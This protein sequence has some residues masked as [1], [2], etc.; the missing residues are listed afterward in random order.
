MRA[1][2]WPVRRVPGFSPR[3]SIWRGTRWRWREEEGPS[4]F[5]Y[6]WVLGW[7]GVWG[8]SRR[9]QSSIT[10]K[11]SARSGSPAVPSAAA[12]RS[13]PGSIG[14]WQPLSIPPCMF[15]LCIQGPKYR[16]EPHLCHRN[17]GERL[18]TFPGG[19]TTLLSHSDAPECVLI[20]WSYPQLK[21]MGVSGES[22]GIFCSIWHLPHRLLPFFPNRGVVFLLF[23]YL[24]FF[25]AGIKIWDRKEHKRTNKQ[26]AKRNYF[27]IESCR[28]R[29]TPFKW[30]WTAKIILGKKKKN[31]NLMGK[32]QGTKWGLLHWR[33]FAGT[34]V[35]FP[36]ALLLCYLPWAQ[37]PW[38]WPEPSPHLHP[39]DC[40]SWRTN[41]ALT[42]NRA[43]T[44]Y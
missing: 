42:V 4:G 31:R 2:S 19:G 23:P 13:L 28:K 6:G 34:S 40:P 17:P 3:Y 20:N 15:F 1:D 10:G 9:E 14:G 38:A 11:V 33:C 16:W 5:G 22:P 44:L 18:K 39:R 27:C 43:L 37:G 25:P 26:K 41:H 29:P 7:V 36:A 32:V 24:F 8:G 30:H 12:H 35:I 21:W